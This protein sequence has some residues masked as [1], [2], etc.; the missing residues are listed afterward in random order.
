VDDAGLLIDRDRPSGLLGRSDAGQELFSFRIVF[1]RVAVSIVCDDRSVLSDLA[2]VLGGAEAHADRTLNIRL[3]ST[4]DSQALATFIDADECALTVDDLLLARDTPDFPFEVVAPIGEGWTSFAWRGDAVPLLSFRG[5]ECRIDQR[6]GWQRAFALLVLHRVYRLRDDAIFFHAATVGVEGR[7][8]LIV[9]AKGEGKS[10]TS[11]SLAVRGHMLLGDETAC[12]LPAS[13]ELLP[14]RR[15]VGIKRGPRS[16]TIEEALERTGTVVGEVIR[17]DVDTLIDTVP[18][19]VTPLFAV[20][21][22]DPFAATPHLE[23]IQVTREEIARLQPV[24]SSLVNAPKGRRL[25]ELA[26][27][28]ATSRVFRLTPADPDAT[29]L[30]IENTVLGLPPA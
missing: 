30:L 20:L 5:R 24:S 12:Y 10:T 11:L 17:V 29:A 28:L 3:E 1:A 7:G 21:F 25:V 8:L 16:R 6:E 18:P 19:T 13:N 4:G 27:M 14:V 9:G 22:L 2:L 15:P 23:E 26:R